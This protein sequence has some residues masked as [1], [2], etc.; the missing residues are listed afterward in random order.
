MSIIG[1]DQ[2][3][4]CNGVEI[5]IGDEE[6]YHEEVE[7]YVTLRQKINVY[8]SQPMTREDAIFITE[9]LLD[10]DEIDYVE[11]SVITHREV[12]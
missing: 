5:R 7:V 8:S 3:I 2:E 9:R 1:R 11:H 4:H 6:T 10:K 12:I